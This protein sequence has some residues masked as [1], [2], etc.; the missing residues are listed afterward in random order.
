MHNLLESFSEILKMKN[1]KRKLILFFSPP[2]IFFLIKFLYRTCKI[3]YQ[4]NPKTLELLQKQQSF[5]LSFWHGN[6]LMQPCL[7]GKILK[8]SPQK[9]YVLISQHFDGNIISRAI[10]LFGIDSLRGSSSKGNI[11]VL[12]LALRKLQENDFV[13]ITPDGPRGPYHSVA[14][15]IV[16]LSQKSKKPIVS[17]QVHYQKF[18]E[19]KSWDRFQI[20]K[21]F[22]RITYILKE[23]LWIENLDLDK[24]KAQI[25]RVMEA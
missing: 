15:G 18:W 8:N 21:P 22:S 3:Q 20:P 14:D 24:A 25:Q 12:L 5:I 1:L 11:K 2:L 19:F 9:A 23:P 17:S 6:L 4:I 13:V 16:L 7:F 10:K